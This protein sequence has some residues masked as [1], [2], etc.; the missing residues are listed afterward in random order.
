MIKAETPNLWEIKAE[1]GIVKTKAVLFTALIHLARLVNVERNLNEVQMGEIANDIVSDYGYMK[2]EEI[3]F[4]F[5]NAVRSEKIFGRLDYNVVMGWIKEYSTERTELCIDISNQEET[6]LANETTKSSAA[7]SWEQYLDNLWSLAF[8]AD[9]DA[10]GKLFQIQDSKQS[11]SVL[12]TSEEKHQKEVD[13]KQFY[14][15]K[16]L[17]KK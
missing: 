5:K 17:K 4:I 6:R 8:Y 3:K 7:I 2:V 13:F 11:K 15:N 14:F 1:L 10:V 16:Y 9:A 12:L